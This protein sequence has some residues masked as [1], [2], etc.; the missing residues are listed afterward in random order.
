MRM[1]YEERLE[2]HLEKKKIEINKKSIK[3]DEKIKRQK[4]LVDEIKKDLGKKV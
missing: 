1:N 3:L 4:K 2:E